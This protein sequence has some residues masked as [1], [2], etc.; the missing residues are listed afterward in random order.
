[1]ALQSRDREVGF[2]GSDR[3]LIGFDSSSRNVQWVVVEWLTFEVS[4][5]EQ[6]EWLS[7]DDAVWSRFLEGCDG[8]VRK[9]MWIE[10][11]DPAKVHA[12]IW[13]EDRNKW[14]QISDETVRMV[15]LKMGRFWRPCS[16]RT[17][18]IVRDG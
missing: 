14:R 8:F 17:F 11:G 3:F 5:G 7:I 15:D 16:M 6:D 2:G 4:P 13:W 12:V 10:E 18:D 1:M 9:Q